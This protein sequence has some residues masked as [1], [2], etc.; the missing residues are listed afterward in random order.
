MSNKLPA[1]IAGLPPENMVGKFDSDVLPPDMVALLHAD[2]M[3]VMETDRAVNEDECMVIDAEG[4]EFWVSMTKIPLRSP[5]GKVI[6]L[7]GMGRPINELHEAREKLTEERNL[8][9][10]LIDILPDYIFVKDR[11]GRFMMSNVAHAAAAGLTPDDLTGKLAQEVFSDE[12]APQFREDDRKVMQTDQPMINEERMTTNARG[13]KRWVLT[14]KIPLHSPQGDVTGL[15]GI[16]RDI[17]ERKVGEQ[18]RLDLALEREKVQLLQSFITATSHDIRTPLTVIS[19]SLYLLEKA[20]N[21]ETQKRHIDK[22]NHEVQRMQKL[23]DDMLTMAWLDDAP[24]PLDNQLCQV[25]FLIDNILTNQT[26]VAEKKNLSLKFTPGEVP[27]IPANHEALQRAISNIVLNAL[28]Y[29]PEGGQITIS[30]F[31]ENQQIAIRVTDTGIGILPED[32]PHIFERFYRADKARNTDKGGMGLG[33]S[34]SQQIVRAHHGTI[35]ATST[36]DQGSVFTIW[37]PVEP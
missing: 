33:L 19:S 34:I 25:N 8:L 36:P 18:H 15:V 30:T 31:S 14:T 5:Q 6:G 21:P 35:D 37:L 20:S 27:Y 16:S 10:T 28:A 1:A 13:E 11:D 22:L 12:V 7:V 17:T 26:P 32:L 4:N 23:L 24:L 3:Q 2:D 29:T 9:R